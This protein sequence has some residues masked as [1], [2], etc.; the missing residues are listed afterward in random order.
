MG[1]Q[2]YLLGDR[3]SHLDPLWSGLLAFSL[4][5]PFTLVPAASLI[6]DVGPRLGSGV[7]SHRCWLP[8]GAWAQPREFGL[9]SR[10]PD[11]P[12]PAVCCQVDLKLKAGCWS[13]FA[14]CV[15]TG[16]ELPRGIKGTKAV[17]GERLA[18]GF[19]LLSA[20][21]DYWGLG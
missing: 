10:G 11:G 1:T 15:N 12:S 21:P 18:T 8:S 20:L 7:C 4:I 9:C 14:F 5:A 16:M 3:G 2:P 6:E 13:G 17:A 19:G